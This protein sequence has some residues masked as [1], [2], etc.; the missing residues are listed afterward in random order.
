MKKEHSKRSI[1]KSVL[2]G[3]LTAAAWALGALFEAGA[4]GIQAFLEPSLYADFPSSGGVFFDDEK[5]IKKKGNPKYKGMTIRQSL[6]RLEKLGFV[7]IKD[8]KYALTEKGK[9]LVDY[10]LCR[11]KIKKQKWDGKYRVV[12]FDIPENKRDIRAWLRY[13]LSLLGYKKL[14]QSVFISKKPLPADIIKEIK[15]QKMGNYVNY[16]LVDKIYKNVV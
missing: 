11:K 9:E 13:E 3:S 10:V 8:S 16:L 14:Q 12:I 15:K 1:T 2:S 5:P 4:L 6:R 7:E